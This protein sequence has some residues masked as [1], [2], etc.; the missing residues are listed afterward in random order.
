[1]STHVSLIFLAE[2]SSRIQKCLR[3]RCFT[4]R[5]SVL[6]LMA[7]MAML[8]TNMLV[9][10]REGEALAG[11]GE[12]DGRAD[13]RSAD[14]YAS[15]G[16]A[17][18]AACLPNA[19]SLAVPRSRALLRDH[20]ISATRRWRYTVSFQHSVPQINSLFRAAQLNNR[21]LF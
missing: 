13:F 2:I 21:L 19:R 16:G 20:K 9:G 4:R 7:F 14:L 10:E 11:G 17:A 5:N 6:S 3:S 1:M 12:E 18:S 15:G 8:S